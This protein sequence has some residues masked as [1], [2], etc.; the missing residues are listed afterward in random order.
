M[1]AT[2][3]ISALPEFT[4][5]L[6]DIAELTRT[7][8]PTAVTK[9]H[10]AADLKQLSVLPRYEAAVMGY[11]KPDDRRLDPGAF[12]V[13]GHNIM[14]IHQGIRR[15]ID[16]GLWALEHITDYAA[17]LDLLEKIQAGRAIKQFAG[18]AILRATQLSSDLWR[19]SG[20]YLNSDGEGKFIA[21]HK[22]SYTVL[23]PI[24]T[25][26][27]ARLV[28]LALNRHAYRAHGYSSGTASERL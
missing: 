19:R 9:D 14:D 1:R 6:L 8:D 21:A 27:T 11:T 5:A 12:H 16:N 26:N 7:T 13:R 2:Q 20:G 25:K 3:V 18:F 4:P 28:D 22:E 15:G 23:K 24:M 17:Q 10:L